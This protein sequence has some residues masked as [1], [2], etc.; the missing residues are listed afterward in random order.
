MQ[1]LLRGDQ[2]MA[3]ITIGGETFNVLIE[4]R[5]DK[6]VLMLAHP[7]A[8]NLHFW[9]PQ[10]P[11]LLEHFRLLRYDARGHGAT[12]ADHG[13]YSIERLG[14]DAIAVMD[15]LGIEKAHWL[16]VSMG[17]MTALWCL[18]HA[19][20]RIDRA[21]LAGTAAHIPG[22]DMWNN[23]IH[24][25]RQ[26]GMEGVAEASAER[27]FTKR[28]REAEPQKVEQVM[29]MVRAT[30][31]HGY[32]AAC[33]AIRDMDLREAIRGITSKVLVIAGRHDPSTPPGMAALI[34][35]S[36]E[37]AQLITLD[38][39]HFS[40]IED[41]ENFTKAVIDFLTAP[42]AGEKKAPPRRRLAAR[43]AA[44][45]KAPARKAAA[46]KAAARK[47][48]T[49]KA[50][51]RKTAAKKAVKKGAVRKGAVRKP[52]VKKSVVRKGAVKKGAARK[53]ALKRS[54]A[55]RA[56]AKK[57]P[58]RKLARRTA[59]KKRAVSKKTTGRRKR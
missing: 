17:S 8:T 58:A 14:R 38:A 18:V 32:L 30:P 16:G 19:C 49:K 29:A 43:K 10:A 54:L 2:I 41:E 22:A 33:A 6:P 47:A 52:A 46:K 21:V 40:N 45:A 20:E 55:K 11:A 26:T 59:A 50:P 48:A 13:P 5:E 56:P 42:E 36:I 35:S 27:W 28:F 44:A 15:A 12:T 3:A 57:A 4:G 9:D 7:I 25:A 51:A 37:G 24:M 23:R 1:S 31:L 39:S 53:G 34:A